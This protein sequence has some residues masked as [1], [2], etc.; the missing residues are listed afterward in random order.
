MFDPFQFLFLILNFGYDMILEN[1]LDVNFVTQLALMDSIV[2]PIYQFKG[3][4]FPQVSV[5]NECSLE[6][7]SKGNV[8]C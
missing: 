8:Y 2:F 4:P 7:D 3:F 6:K 5:M 1:L